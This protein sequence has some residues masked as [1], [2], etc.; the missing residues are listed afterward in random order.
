[1][2]CPYF[3][4]NSTYSSHAALKMFFITVISF[5]VCFSCLQLHY[6]AERINVLVIC[7]EKLAKS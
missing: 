2:Y 7:E 6:R 5:R 3:P 4:T 1:M